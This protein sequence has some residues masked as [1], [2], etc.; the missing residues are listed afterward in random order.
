MLPAGVP[1]AVK[2]QFVAQFVTPNDQK[3]HDTLKTIGRT[4]IPTLNIRIGWLF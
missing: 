1:Q 4:V 2:D 3:V